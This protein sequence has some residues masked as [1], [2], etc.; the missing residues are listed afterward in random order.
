MNPPDV[1]QQAQLEHLLDGI[2]QGIQDHMAWSQKLLRCAVLHV[3]PGDDMLS[4]DAHCRCHLGRWFQTE[5]VALAGFDAA[6]TEELE[7]KHQAMHDAVRALCTQLLQG[8]PARE[9][10]FEAY[11]A[12]QTAT[13]ACLNTLRQRVSGS[14][15]QLDALTGLPLRNGLEYAFQIRCKDAMR[16]G[17]P[18]YLVMVDVDHFK[19]VNDTWGHPVGDLALQHIANLLTGCL[20]ENDI[21]VRYGGEEFLFLLLGHGAENTV[22]RLLQEVRNK[23]MPLSD[24]GKVRMTVTAG[25]T[26]VG[27]TDTLATAISRA[28]HALLQGKQGGRDR[29]VLAGVPPS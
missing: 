7:R 15:L 9:E 28:D 23:P 2:D 24:G 25:L 10:D 20:R 1:Q 14:A 29:Y 4:P 3:S 27:P 5:K 19:V 12:G 17:P 6:V 21:V 16:D 13:V 22:N 8:L 18:L 26:L 11:E